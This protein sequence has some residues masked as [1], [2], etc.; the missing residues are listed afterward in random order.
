MA[1]IMQLITHVCS[2]GVAGE[3]K[4]FV[5][6]NTTYTLSKG[7][8]RKNDSSI[9]PGNVLMGCT[10]AAD[11]APEAATVS[12]LSTGDPSSFMLMVGTIRLP[13]VGT[14]L[15]MEGPRGLKFCVV[16]GGFFMVA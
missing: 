11:L 15:A 16:S 4:F 14:G 13:D 8:R 7:F 3:N 10:L 2:K 5:C 12:P 9:N 1:S 6:S